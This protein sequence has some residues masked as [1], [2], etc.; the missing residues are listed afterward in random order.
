MCQGCTAHKS[1]R[2]SRSM[3]PSL[4]VVAIGTINL[5]LGE[6]A[7]RHRVPNLKERAEQRGPPFLEV[8]VSLEAGSRTAWSIYTHKTE[9]DPGRL[10]NPLT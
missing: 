8:A 3:S 1:D 7:H 2:L 4:Y 6:A 5:Q 10:T 9:F